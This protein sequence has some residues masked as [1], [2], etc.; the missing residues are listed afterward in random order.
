MKFS[1]G[2]LIGFGAGYYLGTKAG[3]ERYHQIEDMLDAVR[4]TDGYQ[5]LRDRVSEVAQQGTEKLGGVID[6]VADARRAAGDADDG[7]D[8]EGILGDPTLN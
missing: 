1:T 3:R 2:L 6:E 4:R 8:A 5:Q 7:L